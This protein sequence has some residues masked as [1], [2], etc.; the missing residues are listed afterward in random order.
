VSRLPA[1]GSDRGTWG[2]VL[3]DYLSQTLA[4]DGTL[5]TDAVTTAALADTSVTLPKL[6][7]QVQASLAKAETAL[8]TASITGKLDTAVAAS[9]YTP[10]SRTVAGKPLSANITLTPTD[11]GAEVA[12]LSAGTMITLNA[13]YDVRG[14]ICYNVKKYGAV[15][16]GVTDDTAAI[17]AMIAGIV[18]PPNAFG[19][20]TVRIH[21][22]AGRY[23]YSG[24]IN[25]T[26]KG[27]ISGDGPQ[28]TIIY[29]KTGATGD[30]ITL[31]AASST[32]RDINLDG[33]SSG[34]V[35]GD[36]IVI[37]AGYGT[38][39]NVWN[40]KAKENAITIGKTAVAIGFKITDTFIRL[41]QGYG[42]LTTA[43][44]G[45]TDGMISNTDIGQC[46]L[47]GIR[48]SN[49]AQNLSLVHVWGNGIGA[50]AGDRYGIW[51]NSASNIL[52][53]CQSESNLNAGIAVTS[54]GSNGNVI[55]GAKIWGNTTQGIYVLNGARGII[56]GCEVYNNGV[57]NTGTQSISFSAIHLEGATEWVIS[58]NNIY[59]DGALINP[60]SYTV[61]PSNPFLGRA[62]V[63]THA[64][65][66]SEITAADRN[67]LSGNMMRKERTRSGVSYSIASGCGV[68]DIWTGNN[69]GASG[70]IAV[71]S[72]AT[73]VIPGYA[74]S[75]VVTI[76]GT[77]QV[78]TLTAGAPARRIT[79]IFTD[80][81]PGG[82]V[83]GSNLKLAGNFAPAAG[84][85]ISLVCDGTNWYETARSAT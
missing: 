21:F 25:L 20:V 47:S 49:G 77:A 1:P 18:S 65:A 67:V 19:N 85:T 11:V 45:S 62:A 29:R 40:T 82:M 51:L 58:G 54:T 83:D 33:N 24:N 56:E 69:T 72:A 68:G 70:I 22:P 44:S 2:D 10:L 26:Y 39:Q 34:A 42:I 79:L 31:S 15:G 74:D 80:P 36:N 60:G 3:N 37:D 6:T 38:I 16:D 9:T 30:L 66:F 7:S 46:Y 5:K 63:L 12:G 8:Q 61:A 75:G 43:A 50:V 4:V 14:E 23:I 59:D 78:T 41:A 53:G 17:N 55:I 73:T 57:I 32:I 84:G 35:S 52:I 81:A 71:A 28:S 64:F 48:L 27:T 76:T 13:R